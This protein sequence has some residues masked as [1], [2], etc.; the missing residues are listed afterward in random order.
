MATPTLTSL[1]DTFGLWP[2]LGKRLAIFA[3]AHLGSGDKG[4]ATLERLK[5]ISGEDP[6]DVHR[7][8][9]PS[10]T[11][12]RLPIRFALACNELP[13]FSDNADALASRLLILPFRNSFLGREDRQREAKLRTEASGILNWALAGLRRL[14]KQS[15]FTIP[16]A[17]EDALVEFER[18]TSPVKAFIGDRCELGANYTVARDTLW[19]AWREWADSCGQKQGT[20]S[21]LGVRLRSLL[22]DVGRSQPRDGESRLDLYSGLQLK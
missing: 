19:T 7:K 12:V 21:L 14:R 11:G 22:P 17:S 13:R 5:A 2:L 1:G 20:K 16:K 9:L 18:H 6:V 4:L 15:R 3:D 8:F 10:L